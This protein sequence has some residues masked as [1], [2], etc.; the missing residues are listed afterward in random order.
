[1]ETSQNNNGEKF[2][3]TIKTSV[4]DFVALIPSPVRAPLH[5]G[6]T[7]SRMVQ[8]ILGEGC[9]NLGPDTPLISIIRDPS[10][11]EAYYDFVILR[12]D[13]GLSPS[14]RIYRMHVWKR[15]FRSA[16]ERYGFPPMPSYLFR[17]PAPVPVPTT[18]PEPGIVANMMA[19]IAVNQPE[20][21]GVATLVTFY[22]MTGEEAYRVLAN[23]RHSMTKAGLYVPMRISR[24]GIYRMIPHRLGAKEWM[25]LVLADSRRWRG[26]RNS[27]LYLRDAGPR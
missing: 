11:F 8:R 26:A 7:Q 15:F 1:M 3:I 13:R 17:K 23:L 21:L 6:N 12:G 22:G 10:R 18:C 4:A 27:G 25:A 24:N 14:T 19:A 9:Q 2:S 16:E 20:L 5:R